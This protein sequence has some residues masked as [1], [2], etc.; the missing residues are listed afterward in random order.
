[1]RPYSGSSLNAFVPI[2][3]DVGDADAAAAAV[4]RVEAEVGPIDVLV[5]SAGAARR[6][7]PAELGP[8]G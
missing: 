6:Y 4:R 2:A 1:M 5:N 7:A 3:A 8:A